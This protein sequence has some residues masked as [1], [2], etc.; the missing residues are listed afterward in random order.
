LLGRLAVYPNVHFLTR[1]AAR[2]RLAAR[3]A[4]TETARDR[5]LALAEE[6]RKR[7]EDARAAIQP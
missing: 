6:F 1:Q 7:A 3:R 5:H 2:E 4:L